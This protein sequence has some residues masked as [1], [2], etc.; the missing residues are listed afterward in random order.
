MRSVHA[1]NIL[2]KQTRLQ[3][4]TKD[5]DVEAWIAQVVVQ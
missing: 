3:Q 4:V 1:L 2:L 5:D